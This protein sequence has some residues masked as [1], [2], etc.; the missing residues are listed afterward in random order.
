[1]AADEKY[2][3]LKRDNLAIPI[4]TQ[5]SQKQK[6]FSE[7]LAEFLKSRINFKYFENKDDFHRFCASGI[8][9]SEN[10]VR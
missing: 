8:T 6:T 1:M 3:L 9:A 5:L 7:F 10:V 2:P 4:Q